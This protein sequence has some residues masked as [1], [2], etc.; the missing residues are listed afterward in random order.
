MARMLRENWPAL[1][2]LVGVRF[3]L[4]AVFRWKWIFAPEEARPNSVMGFLYQSFGEAGCRIFTALV[5]VFV[6]LCG[7]AVWSAV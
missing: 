6:M 1:L 7:G 4:G 3:V 2:I 5:G